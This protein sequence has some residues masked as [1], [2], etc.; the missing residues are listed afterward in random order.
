MIMYIPVIENAAITIQVTGLGID[1]F[2]G[3]WKRPMIMYIPVIENAAI[4]IQ[5][6]RFSSFILS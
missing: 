4:T 6:T 3:K 2:G 5:V 1:I